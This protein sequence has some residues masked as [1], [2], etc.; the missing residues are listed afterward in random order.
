M[1]FCPTCAVRSQLIGKGFG[2]QRGRRAALGSRQK[3]RWVDLL[4]RARM[5]SGRNNRVLWIFDVVGELASGGVVPDITRHPVNCRMSAGRKRRM[6]HNSFGVGVF[7]VGIG[8][9]SARFQQIAEACGTKLVGA[10]GQQVGTQAVDRE[11]QHQSR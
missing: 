5:L 8:K 9:D 2:K 7:I 4:P 10:A 6:T 11:L 3:L 1:N